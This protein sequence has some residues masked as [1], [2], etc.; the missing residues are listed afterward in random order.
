LIEEPEVHLH[1]ELQRRLLRFLVDHTKSR[2]FITT[3]SNVFLDFRGDTSI[4]HVTHDGEKSAVSTADANPHLREIIADLGLRASDLLQSNGVVWVEG[5]SDRILLNRWLVLAGSNLVEN[6]HYTVMFYGGACLS[7]V[8]CEPGVP[9]ND[10]ISLL[11]LNRHAFM[12]MDRDGEGAAG[13]WTEAKRRIRGELP[14]NHCWVTLG[15][16]IENY[17][18]QEQVDA[19]VKRRYPTRQLRSASFTRDIRFS[20]AVMRA[21][22]VGS[23]DDKVSYARD[24]AAHMTVADLDVLNL[25]SWITRV[26]D[27]IRSWQELRHNI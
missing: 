6:L 15:R 2:F 12:L 13:R 5:P 24:I 21:A 20:E 16:E 18:S 9:L 23:I 10:L 27:I 11:H 7:H 8:T 14:R 25:R 26:T 3:H 1:P 17:I 22:R 19:Y 4:C